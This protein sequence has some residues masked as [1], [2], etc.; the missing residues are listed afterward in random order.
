MK[1]KDKS[2][3]RKSLLLA[4]EQG[5]AKLL[6]LV[7]SQDLDLDFYCFFPPDKIGHWE[8][9]IFKTVSCRCQDAPHECFRENHAIRSPG[10]MLDRNESAAV[11]K[12]SWVMEWDG[13][14]WKQE[15]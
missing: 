14:R 13:M 6:N 11:V 12:I 3:G 2:L 8:G 7:V 1:R 9:D 15:G 10:S 4:C 5:P